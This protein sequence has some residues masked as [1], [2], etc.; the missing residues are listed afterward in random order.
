M[1]SYVGYMVSV[2]LVVCIYITLVSTP[3]LFNYHRTAQLFVVPYHQQQF[4]TAFS[5]ERE[6]PRA[7]IGNS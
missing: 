1:S 7:D 6:V 5:R 2:E 3:L 4:D